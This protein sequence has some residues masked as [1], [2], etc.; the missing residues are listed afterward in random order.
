MGN[1][2]LQHE[3]LE[4]KLNLPSYSLDIELFMFLT[5]KETLSLDTVCL[6]MK[7]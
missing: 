2:S 6:W 4:H 3:F 7:I 5:H 1:R